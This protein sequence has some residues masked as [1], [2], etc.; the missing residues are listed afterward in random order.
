MS[1]EAMWVISD[2]E[3]AEMVRTGFARWD[4]DGALVLTERGARF[5]LNEMKTA[6]DKS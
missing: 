3:A 6:A 5:T 1:A 2:S 4:S